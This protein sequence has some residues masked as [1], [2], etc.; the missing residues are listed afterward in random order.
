MSTE[1]TNNYIRKKS[2]KPDFEENNFFKGYYL[3]VMRQDVGVDYIEMESGHQFYQKEAK[4]IHIYYV[5][6]GKGVVCINE[7]KYGIEQ[8]DII[9]IPINT[10]FAF[11]GKLKMI[12]IMNP[13]FDIN[14]HTN[15][16]I[17]DL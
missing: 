10:E 2:S 7:H 16:R 12:E 1:I 5:L 15:T 9:E 11:K 3:N 17:N 4:S 14:T 6:D 13:P 8:G